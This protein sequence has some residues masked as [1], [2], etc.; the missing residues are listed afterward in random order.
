M[1]FLFYVFMVFPSNIL[2]SA[3]CAAAT[4]RYCYYHRCHE[5][6]HAWGL[7]HRDEIVGNPDLGTC[8]DYTIKPQNNQKPDEIDFE[9]LKIM[10]GEVNIDR[11]RRLRM[12]SSGDVAEILESSY[13]YGASTKPSPREGRSARI[14]LHKSDLHEVWGEDLGNG[15]R[16]MTKVLLSSKE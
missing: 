13:V 6:G 5:L 12:P 16:L 10:Y 2:S 7:P 4:A 8:L 14:L 9:N 15:R 1:Q 11:G 3:A